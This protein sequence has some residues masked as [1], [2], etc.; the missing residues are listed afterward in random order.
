MEQWLVTSLQ[1]RKSYIRYSY[2]LD[3]TILQPIYVLLHVRNVTILVGVFNKTSL[4]SSSVS[5]QR[6][7]RLVLHFLL[8]NAG[9]SDTQQAHKALEFAHDTPA[10]VMFPM[11]CFLKTESSA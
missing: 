7:A 3:S 9:C 5:H 11:R 8:T 1:L 10:Y 4:N 2:L 6:C